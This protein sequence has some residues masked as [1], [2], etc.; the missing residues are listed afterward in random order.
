M[1]EL[2]TTLQTSKLLSVS[3]STLEHWRGLRKGPPWILISPRCIRYRRNDLD[4]WLNEQFIET[5]Q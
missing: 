3:P 1:S 5:H 2:L 4:A